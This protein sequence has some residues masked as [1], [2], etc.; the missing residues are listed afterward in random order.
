MKIA[1]GRV[2]VDGALRANTDITIRNGAICAIG[3]YLPAEET[4]DATGLMILPG[5]IDT[6]I[7]GFAGRDTMDGADAVR[8]MARELIKHGTTSF[9]ATTMTASPEDTHYAIVGI[10]NAMHAPADG[11]VVL[12]CH[13]EGPFFC[14][15]RKG[16][17]PA[18]HL[19]DPS[20]DDFETMAG[21][22]GQCV[23][24]LALA[25]ELPGANELIGEL[26]GRGIQV[27]CGHT[28]ASY[29]QVMSAVSAGASSVTHIYNA[30]TPLG[31]RDPGAVGAALDSRQLYAEFI[32]DLVHLHPAALRIMYQAKG[33]ELC[34]AITDSMMAGG[35]PDGEYSLGGQKVMVSGGAARLADGTLAGS[36]LTLR[37]S[38]KNMVTKVGVPLDSAIPMYT[39]TPARMIG[40]AR[41]GEL[42]RGYEAD[43]IALDSDFE[44]R[45]AWVGGRRLV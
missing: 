13:M 7:H 37:Q 41:R 12:G 11:A 18:Q 30:M 45:A 5:F 34:V 25:P 1:N 3:E 21:V 17:Q 22:F 10:A 29:E 28:D 24:R 20:V 40:E 9:V 39:S 2:F 44:L 4:Y 35:M 6:H 19:L 36:V 14:K 32:A 42:A 15:K 43:I 26:V 23:R 27:S 8:H 38:L 16:A 33:P 31:H